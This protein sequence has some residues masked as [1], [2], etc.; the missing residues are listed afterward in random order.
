LN[1]T[2]EKT[3]PSVPDTNRLRERIEYVVK[4]VSDMAPRGK[5]LDWDTVVSLSVSKA[6]LV[7]EVCREFSREEFAGDNLL[8]PLYVTYKEEGEKEAIDLGGVQAEMYGWSVLLVM[9]V[10]RVSITTNSQIHTGLHCFSRV[11]L[12][13]CREY[14]MRTWDC[15]NLVRRGQRY[16]QLRAKT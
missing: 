8:R 10:S 11:A 14:S 4:N 13:K 15:W 12:V 6:Q 5:D 9:M 16:H 7:D 3:T 2:S 1:E